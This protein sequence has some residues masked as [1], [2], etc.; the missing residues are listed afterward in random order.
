[1]SDVVDATAPLILADGTLVFP[2]GRVVKL[3]EQGADGT[4]DVIEIPTPLEAQALVLKTRRTTQDLPD[5]PR[6]MN[7]ISVVLSYTLFGLNDEEI[8]L[9]ANITVTQVTRIK[10]LPAYT[11][12]HN[13]LV[14][15]LV[16]AAKEDVRSAFALHSQK[17]LDT[18]VQLMDK[19]KQEVRLAASTQVLDRAG[20]RPVDNGVTREAR[21]NELR[22]VVITKDERALPIT[23][24]LEDTI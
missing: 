6:T 18:M 7:A 2:D 19:G 11:T 4:V 1:M 15:N 13:A 24:D 23:I 14:E 21:N 3:S 10:A 20:L 17:A 5:L 16:I 22:I 12:M 8:A 9:T